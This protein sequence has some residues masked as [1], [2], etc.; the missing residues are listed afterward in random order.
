MRGVHG[1]AGGDDVVGDGD[2]PSDPDR[3]RPVEDRRHRLGVVRAA[4]VEVRVGIDE[5][6]ERLRRL[7][8]GAGS[9]HGPY[10]IYL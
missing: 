10:T 7:G 9:A 1:E 5:R 4:R 8:R 6:R 3:G 2:D